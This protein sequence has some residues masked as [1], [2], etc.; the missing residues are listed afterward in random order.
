MGK[1]RRELARV[2]ATREE[3]E[4]EEEESLAPSPEPPCHEPT[5]NISPIR[6]GESL[7]K[8]HK[9]QEDRCGTSERARHLHLVHLLAVL[10]L[11]R[12]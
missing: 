10:Y 1:G 3:E 7:Y 8:F 11:G 2:L 4:E 5:S 6:I 9:V 12:S